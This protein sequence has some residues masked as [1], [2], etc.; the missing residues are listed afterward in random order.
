[1]KTKLALVVL[2]GGQDSTT[3]LALALCTYG[4]ENVYAVTFDYGQRHSAEID[5]ATRIAAMAGI[6]ARH[7]IIRVPAILKGTSPLVDAGAS[8]EQYQSAA[9]LPGGLEK[10]FVP[11]RNMLFMTIA[12]NRAALLAG[13]GG[14]VDIITGV[15]QEDYG[16]YPDCRQDFIMALE[17]TMRHSLDDPELPSLYI[18]TPLMHKSK[19]QTVEMSE[20]IPGARE[21]LAYSHTCYNGQVPP[22]GKCHACLLR[23]KGYDSARVFDPLL[24]RLKKESTPIPPIS[25]PQIAGADYIPPAL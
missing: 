21:L 14:E 10:T 5:S 20:E 12:A 7:E 3:C 22:C 2:S 4:V 9:K 8:V 17:R 24:E 25:I 13:P 19:R 15:S 1:M 6:Q 11:M 16:G 18:K 23:Q